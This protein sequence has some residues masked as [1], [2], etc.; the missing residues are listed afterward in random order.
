MNALKNYLIRVNQVLSLSEAAPFPILE[1]QIV[2]TFF[3]NH[4]L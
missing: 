3:S 2:N 4:N 1:A